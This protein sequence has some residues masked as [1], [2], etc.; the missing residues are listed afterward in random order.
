[1]ADILVGYPPEAIE[2]LRVAGPIVRGIILD[3]GVMLGIG[4]PEPAPAPDS[5]FE[6]WLIERWLRDIRSEAFRQSAD[7]QYLQGE[8]ERGRS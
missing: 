1:M 7:F 4:A 6:Q 3:N 5:A 8:W 2:A